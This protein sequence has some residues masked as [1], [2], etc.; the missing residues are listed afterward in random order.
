MYLL[1]SVLVEFLFVPVRVT[2]AIKN[3]SWVI[4]DKLAGSA[5]PGRSLTPLD[6]YILADLNDLYNYGIRCLLSL[7]NM[8]ASFSGLCDEAGIKW[9]SFPIP[10]FGIPSDMAAF[11]GTIQRSLQYLK[12]DMPLCVHCYAGIGRTGIVLA[13]IIGLYCSVDGEEA[14]EKVRDNRSAIE[15]RDQAVFVNSFLNTAQKELK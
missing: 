2:M 9:L 4:P 1:F 12:E 10:D 13:S 14:I 3:F 6:A 7:R 11:S 5:M 8:P 15:T